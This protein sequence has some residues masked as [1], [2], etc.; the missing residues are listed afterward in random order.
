MF[1]VTINA[2]IGKNTVQWPLKLSVDLLLMI[3]SIQDHRNHTRGPRW[4]RFATTRSWLLSSPGPIGWF[5]HSTK[6]NLCQLKGKR[7]EAI[8]SPGS[9]LSRNRSNLS[10]NKAI[11]EKANSTSSCSTIPI[12][13]GM[14]LVPNQQ[15]LCAKWH[16]VYTEIFYVS[17]RSCFHEKGQRYFW[18]AAVYQQIHKSCK[19]RNHA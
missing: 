11:K 9:K 7:C 8:A 4:G 15:L 5:R 17:I 19:R 10:I 6:I 16:K 3:P 2:A 1:G 18:T 14:F 12:D 13:A